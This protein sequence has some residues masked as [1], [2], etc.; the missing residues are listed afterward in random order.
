MPKKGTHVGIRIRVDARG[1]IRYE[2]SFFRDPH[3]Y[4]ESFPSRFGAKP[5]NEALKAAVAWRAMMLT[6]ATQGK[7]EI[8]QRVQ[9][10]AITFGEA[11]D[12]FLEFGVTVRQWSRGKEGGSYRFYRGTFDQAWFAFRDRPLKSIRQEEIVEILQSRLA[13]RFAPWE[14]HEK[15]R[16]AMTDKG[17]RAVMEKGRSRRSVQAYHQVI[18]TLM[19]WVVAPPQRWLAKS[20]CE[21]IDMRSILPRKKHKKPARALRMHELRSILRHAP[22]E[23]DLMFQV[24]AYLGPRMDELYRMEWGWI[25]WGAAEIDF[26]GKMGHD[27]VPIPQGL[28][29]ELLEEFRRRSAAGDPCRFLFSPE[30]KPLDHR[31]SLR[32]ACAAAGIAHQGVGYHCFRHTLGTLLYAVSGNNA[33]V[34]AAMLRHSKESKDTTFLYLHADRNL[35]VRPYLEELVRQVENCAVVG[36]DVAAAMGGR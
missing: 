8:P 21:D 29:R 26:D 13:G 15:R 1:N 28:L 9:P 4:Y 11:C 35:D 2:A 10:K 16:E 24:L 20:P 25:R 5:D 22:P 27:T 12:R 18:S 6:K 32:A 30:G 17:K 19:D 14:G 23:H 31:K 34:P 33:L 7:L 36:I 3:R